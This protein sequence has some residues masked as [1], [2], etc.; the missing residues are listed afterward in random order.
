M[1]RPEGSQ[2]FAMRGEKRRTKEEKYCSAEGLNA[3][4]VTCIN[5]RNKRKELR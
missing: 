5:K 2:F 4:R 3:G 1:R